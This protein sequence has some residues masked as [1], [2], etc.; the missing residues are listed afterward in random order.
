[1]AESQPHDGSP[2]KNSQAVFVENTL[3]GFARRY[4]R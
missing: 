1:M 4:L 3:A 2:R